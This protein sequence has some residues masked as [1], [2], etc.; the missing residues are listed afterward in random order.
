[1]AKEV[2]ASASKMATSRLSDIIAVGKVAVITGASSGIGLA[3]SKRLAKAGMKVF[4]VDV[5]TSELQAACPLVQAVAAAPTDVTAVT[6]DV[7][8]LKTLETLRDQAFAVNGTV[9]F[10]MNNA[11]TNTGG[12]ALAPIDDWHKTIDV[13]T[14]GPIHGC[15]AFVPAMQKSGAPGIIV[16]TGSKQGIT[17]PPGNLAYNVSKAALK[18]Y[19]EG[20]QHELRSAQGSRLSAA[21][22][23]PGWTNTSIML[24]AKRDV[25]VAAG[26][27]FDPASVFFHEANPQPGA[28]MPDQVVDFMMEELERGRFYI[29][30][31]DNDVDRT[32]D[33]L[34]MTWAMQDITE[35]RAPLSRWHPDYKDA[36]QAFLDQNKQ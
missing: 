28:W 19:T 31:P 21:L 2:A 27:D 23:V 29:I 36:F 33:N 26:E 3:T 1:M 14:W 9:S 8:D 22:L 18:A 12:G 4:M 30:C 5:D 10:L 7:R 34:R 11:G 24:K 17:M 13:N 35:D 25:A 16:N 15:Q 6:C 20:L 32:T